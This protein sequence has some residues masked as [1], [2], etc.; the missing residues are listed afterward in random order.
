MIKHILIFGTIFLLINTSAYALLGSGINMVAKHTKLLPDL[1]II[2]LSKMSNEISGTKKIGK[3]LGEKNLPKEVLEDTYI[4]IAIHQKKISRE[5][6][7][8]FYKYLHGVDGFRT[9]M[10][11]VIGNSPQKTI[12]HLNELQI[13]KNAS[14]YG[15]KAI[16]IGTKYQ[17]GLKK[18]PTD[19]DIILKKDN[20][21]FIIEAKDYSSKTKL[22]M[23][24]YRAD[25]D[26][27][28]AYK[29]EHDNEKVIAI[30]SITNKPD[31]KTY[32][33]L[34]K[35]EARRRNIE[36]LFGTPSQQIVQVNQ[37]NRIIQ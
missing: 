11:K 22:P 37:L 23:D 20:K 33:K 9:T 25:L 1:E 21:L 32:L 17:D 19:I 14:K 7:E 24:K 8:E 36:L 3:Y 29:K 35:K 15:F 26:T 28:N 18:A 30:F 16:G 2:K 5:E 10:S 31:N 13:A 12:G 27:L 6:A 34:L 4:R